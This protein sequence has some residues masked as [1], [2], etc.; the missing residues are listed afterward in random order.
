MDPDG[1]LLRNLCKPWHCNVGTVDGQR[2]VDAAG[3][4][5]GGNHGMAMYPSLV[6]KSM[7]SCQLM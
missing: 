5:E 4:D 2:R 3:L 1:G 6:A 7:F